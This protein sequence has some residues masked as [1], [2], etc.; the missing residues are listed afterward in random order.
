MICRIW[1]GWTELGTANAYERLLKQEIFVN[2]AGR[3][4]EGYRGLQLLRQ[5]REGEV[6]FVTLMWFDTLAAVRSFAGEDYE[7][8][9]VPPKA[10]AMLSRYDLRSQHYEVREE[11]VTLD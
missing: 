7:Q 8:A 9:V 11:Q 6:E 4:I 3:G 2:I 5:E 1:R 10:R